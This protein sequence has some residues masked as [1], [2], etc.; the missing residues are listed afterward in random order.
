MKITVIGTGYVGLVSGVCLSEMG[1]DVTCI[2]TNPKVVSS[3]KKGNVTFYEPGIEDLILKNIK[4]QKLS[5]TTS[6]KKG[7]QN[8]KVFF[9]CVGT[10]SLK[11][12][13]CDT[14]FI[15][16]VS[17]KLSRHL[18]DKSIVYVKST[19]PIGTNEL[20]SKIIKKN[21]KSNNKFYVA[22][23][24]E[25]L[26]EGDAI[27]DFMNP[28]RIIIGTEDD[29][30]IEIS[31]KIYKPLIIKKKNIIF[32]KTRSAELSKYA[33]NAFLATKIS[34][35]NELSMLA[36][37]Y[38]ISI[39][40]VKHAMSFD[41]RIGKHFLNAGLGFGGSCF[42]KD[43]HSLEYVFKQKKIN[44]P[45]ISATI[46][47]NNNQR[48]RFLQKAY[49]LYEHKELKKK[50]LLVWGLTFKPNTDDVRESQSIKLIKNLS[51]K[52]NHLYLYDPKGIPNAKKDLK[53]LTNITYLNTQ[54]EFISKCDALI[55]CTEWNEFVN[56]DIEK[57]AKLKDRI[58][59]DG[60]NVLDEALLNKSGFRYISLAN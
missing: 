58:I 8:T 43:L 12:G 24:P 33:S 35:M 3:L 59:L 11:N 26:K 34:F 36:D 2:D 40:D 5:F 44:S 41:T 47:V 25:F 7:T 57:V 32:L 10:P 42:P 20:V 13:S 55:L 31:K 1:H 50:K 28:D 19:V 14:S 30:V 45:L 37:E 27:N 4:Q 9:I 49:A 54:Y 48:K 16:D 53:G 39:N 52:Y 60:R 17:Q 22:S 56:F 18:T 6:Y 23:N 38:K 29:Y 51:K 21:I 15:N 46:E